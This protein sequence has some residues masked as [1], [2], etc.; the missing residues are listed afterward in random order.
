MIVTH[1]KLAGGTKNWYLSIIDHA[2]YADVVLVDV[3]MCMVQFRSCGYDV[4]HVILIA[5]T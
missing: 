4:G 5:V 2:Y 3:W 1:C